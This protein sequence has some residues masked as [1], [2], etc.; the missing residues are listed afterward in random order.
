MK[1]LAKIIYTTIILLSIVGILLF[2][3]SNLKTSEWAWSLIATPLLILPLL[4]PTLRN[5]FRVIAKKYKYTPLLAILV[6]AIVVAAVRLYI[7][8]NF[9]YAP[10]SDPMAFYDMSNK[11][12]QGLGITGDTYIAFFPYLAA[13]TGLLGLSMQVI[14]DAWLSVIVINSIFD[15]MTAVA[16]YAV[17]KQLSKKESL[18]PSLGAI[19]WIVSPFSTL[20]SIVSLPI[21]AVNFF[22][23]LS[24]LVSILTLKSFKKGS[25]LKTL[26][27]S[28]LLGATLALGSSLRPVFVIFIIAMAVTLTLV[29][30][31]SKS[32]LNNIILAIPS[33][34]LTFICYSLLQQL[35]ISLVSHFTGIETSKSS[36]GWSIFVGANNESS[37]K[38]NIEDESR[39]HNICINLSRT[40]CHRQLTTEGLK[41]YTDYGPNQSLDLAIRKLYI[42]SSNQDNIYNADTSVEGYQGST[43]RRLFM[44]YLKIYLVFLLTL[45]TAYLI[46]I[47]K[48]KKINIERASATLIALVFIGLSLSTIL[49]ETSERYAQV[50]YPLLAILSTLGVGCV[51]RITSPNKES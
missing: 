48:Y 45:S 35:N 26:V 29:V 34:L 23:A 50:I 9:S 37:G 25:T 3:A 30:V 6:S 20:F 51:G 7:Y 8:F 44:I 18:L 21:N 5:R 12:N 38:W 42:F 28:M 19:I 2:L 46:S 11:I 33:I 15:I 49:V 22:I 17:L 32:R 40:E 13:Y 27:L 47:Y 39:M 16:I 14:P 24:V 10:I 31:A 41:R 36:S 4:V 43:I 1:L